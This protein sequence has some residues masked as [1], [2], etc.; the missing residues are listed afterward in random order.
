MTKPVGSIVSRIIPAHFLALAASSV[1]VSA[2]AYLLLTST[3][4]GY[5]QRILHDHA[6][7]VARYLSVQ[8][9]RW[10][11]SLPA[12]LAAVYARGIGGYALA[13]SDENGHLLYSSLPQ[14]ED[15]LKIRPTD[16]RLLQQRV[17]GTDYYG[18]VYPVRA[19]GHTA[20]IGVAQNYASPDVIIDDVVARFL[21]RIAWIMLPIFALLLFLD[22]ILIRRVLRPVREASDVA[23]HIS[24]TRPS[25]RLPAT[26]LP[27]EIRPLANA[28]NQAL[29]R[30]EQ[31]LNSQREFTADAAH[32]MRTPLA[33]LRTR[34]DTTLEPAA[35]KE[36]QADI[37]GIVR[38]L[39]QLLELAELEATSTSGWGDVDL[40]ELCTC[41]VALMAPLAI[42]E[43]K[44]VE[45]SGAEERLIVWCNAGM[46]TRALRNLV[47]NAI[48]FSPSGGAV[49]VDLAAPDVILVKDRGPGVQPQERETIFRRFWRKDRQGKNHSGLGLAIVAKIAQ[50]HGGSI[51]V[52]DSPGG[53]AIFEL[54]VTGDPTDD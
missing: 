7:A 9:G 53:G 3:V 21:R 11:L 19:A 17:H 14:G 24:P 18:L 32:E 36:L 5:E 31:A 54:Q 39:D 49:E 13:V 12:E 46:I 8:E 33:I 10:K 51:A 4:N 1:V 28:V 42:A 35:A 29:D 47:E 41:V 34:I 37:D 38:I 43:G 27:Q 45:F 25:E 26:Q 16:E 48:R 20:W 50:I 6:A 52:K 15:L 22:V 40:R 30:L 44:S 2:A 23:A